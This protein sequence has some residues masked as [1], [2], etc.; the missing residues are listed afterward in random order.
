MVKIRKLYHPETLK[1]CLE[2]IIG[3]R[4]WKITPFIFKEKYT[5]SFKDELNKNVYVLNMLRYDDENNHS[6]IVGVY[7]SKEKAEN[8]GKKEELY[9][10]NKYTYS[11]HETLIDGLCKKI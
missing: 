1:Y 11:I 10:G 2:L 4:S 6:Y 3:W 5:P 8:I 9:R 7:S